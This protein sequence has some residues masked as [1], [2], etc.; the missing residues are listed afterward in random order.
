MRQVVRFPAGHGVREQPPGRRAVAAVERRH[1]FLDEFLG[2]A[3][4]LGQR[5]AGAVDVRP[6]S[7]VA[8]IEEQHPAPDVDGLLVAAGEI[9]LEPREQQFV[10]LGVAIQVGLDAS[11]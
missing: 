1:A 10:Y 9:L 7:R 4:A 8:P 3:L 2:R 6:R 11:S 5:A